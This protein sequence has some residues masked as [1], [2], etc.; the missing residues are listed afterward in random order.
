MFAFRVVSMGF[1]TRER[2]VDVF[3]FKEEEYGNRFQDR[4]EDASTR[5]RQGK[6]L[7]NNFNVKFRF[8][9]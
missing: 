9:L 5:M 7:V 8:F 4:F 3:K 1:V 6:I 2:E